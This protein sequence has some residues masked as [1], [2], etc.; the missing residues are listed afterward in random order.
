MM[1]KVFLMKVSY[2]GSTRKTNKLIDQANEPGVRTMETTDW[3][4]FDLLWGLEL[5]VDGMDDD[6]VVVASGLGVTRFFADAALR[7][8]HQM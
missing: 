8:M 6:E 3:F 5:V 2:L 1:M 4:R 7:D